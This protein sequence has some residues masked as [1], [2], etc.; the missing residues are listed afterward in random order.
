MVVPQSPYCLKGQAGSAEMITYVSDCSLA[1]GGV[2][3][4]ETLRGSILQCF[5][6]PGILRDCTFRAMAYLGAS[7]LKGKR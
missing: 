3:E 1:M 5:A 4:A 7:A 6:L 2:G